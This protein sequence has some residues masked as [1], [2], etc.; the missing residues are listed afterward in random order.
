HHLGYFLQLPRSQVAEPIGEI[1]HIVVQKRECR[2]ASSR[3]YRVHLITSLSSTRKPKDM[4]MFNGIAHRSSELY[5]GVLWRQE[6]HHRS[7]G[8]DR[9]LNISL[10]IVQRLV[11]P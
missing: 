10:I 4:G 6:F 8:Q 9:R 2:H 7:S 3:Y 11:M 5:N 1:A